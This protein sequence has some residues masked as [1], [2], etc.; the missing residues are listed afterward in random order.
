MN[1]IKY[2][3]IFIQF[4]NLIYACQCPVTPWTKELANQNDVILRGVIKNIYLHQNDYTVA[5]VE[6]INL[7]KGLPYKVY[8]IL[9]PENDKCAISINIGE[10]WLI[11][12]KS[13]QINSCKI[14][15]C[16]LSRKKFND[17]T[18]DF[19]IATHTITYDEELS[20]LQEY[21]PEI[22]IKTEETNYPF[23]KNIIPD[24]YEVYIYFALSLIGFL[25]FLYLTKKY[26]K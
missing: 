15:W 5:E 9:F 10:E 13:Q 21:F 19:F 4:F 25:I 12:G 8:R 2:I 26:L 11:Y 18:S 3:F 20:K 23:H 7:F 6:V 1:F 16:G 14:I 24:K 17:E 22:K